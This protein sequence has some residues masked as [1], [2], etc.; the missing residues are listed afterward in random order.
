MRVSRIIKSYEDLDDA[1]SEFAT[2]VCQERLS[3]EGSLEYEDPTGRGTPD[4]YPGI[5]V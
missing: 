4:K 3:G 2:L 1:V 5:N